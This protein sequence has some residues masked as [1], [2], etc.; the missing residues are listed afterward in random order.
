MNTKAVD[1][2]K[3]TQPPRSD[4]A[5]NPRGMRIKTRVRAGGDDG[6]AE[7]RGG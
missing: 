7:S 2:T 5:S 1:E 4:K 6:W 3:L